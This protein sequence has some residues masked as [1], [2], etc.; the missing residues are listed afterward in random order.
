M[1]GA[2]RLEVLENLE[3]LDNLENLEDLDNLENL[4]D[5]DNLG[6]SRDSL[7]SIGTVHGAGLHSGHRRPH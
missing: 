4:E 2:E 1:K 3:D 7:S 5:L 6:C